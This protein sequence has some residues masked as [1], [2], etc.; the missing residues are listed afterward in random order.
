MNYFSLPW[1]VLLFFS[2]LLLLLLLTV[3]AAAAAVVWFCLF[4][5]EFVGLGGI[6]LDHTF[7]SFLVAK[8][9]SK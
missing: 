3:A 4:D 1:F 2:G 8:H 9:S 6:F 7:G 5:S